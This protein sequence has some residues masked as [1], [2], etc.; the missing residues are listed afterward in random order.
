MADTC[1][2]QGDYAVAAD[3]AL[4]SLRLKESLGDA[5]EIG[6]SLIMLAVTE[7]R[8]AH[9]AT[10]A[11]DLR[12]AVRIGR[13]SG[14][15]PVAAQ[16]L[17]ELGTLEA[18]NGNYSAALADLRESLQLQQD[19]G[20]TVEAARMLAEIA[21]VNVKMGDARSAADNAG[22]A[23][24]VL[25]ER[26]AVADLVTASLTAGEADRLVGRDAEARTAFEEAIAATEKTRDLVAGGEFSKEL[27]LAE[28]GAAYREMTALEVDEG[29][30]DAALAMAERLR[31]RALLDLL[32]G[33]RENEQSAMSAEERQQESRLRRHV[34]SLGAQLRAAQEQSAP[35]ARMD[36]IR[37]Q[38]ESA[39]A[40]LDAFRI[41]LYAAHP[42]LA[43]RRGELPP[44]RTC[45]AAALLPPRGAAILEYALTPRGLFLFVITGGHGCRVHRL[46]VSREI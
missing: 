2:R 13:E 42:E 31:A 15:K 27:F 1:V 9:Y 41:A 14:R 36:R 10:A 6:S 25:Q 21:R 46:Q 20:Q 3:D 28:R 40:E 35:Q 45:D 11:E 23:R 29:H 34:V 17:G 44:V 43:M 16:A 19:I 38:L 37:R 24:A 12:R 32:R 22:N 7:E 4:K 26:G 33:A 8:A 30:V 18:E 39:R 5:S